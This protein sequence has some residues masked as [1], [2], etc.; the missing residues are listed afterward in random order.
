MERQSSQY[1]ERAYPP[2]EE[3]RG[4]FPQRQGNRGGDSTGW[5]L[6]GMVGLGLAAWMVWH[7]GPDVARYIK[8]ERM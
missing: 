1:P 6:A 4:G 8:I 3:N 7:F 5:M 2:A